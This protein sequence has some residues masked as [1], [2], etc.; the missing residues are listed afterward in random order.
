MSKGMKLHIYSS[1]KSKVQPWHSDV[2]IKK[3]FFDLKRLKHV[4]HPF[5]LVSQEWAAIA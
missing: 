3:L 4:P 2:I 1:C 5:A